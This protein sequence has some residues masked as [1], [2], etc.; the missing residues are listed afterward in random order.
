MMGMQGIAGKEQ[1]IPKLPASPMLKPM[2]TIAASST[3]SDI[4]KQYKKMILIPALGAALILLPKP[5]LYIGQPFVQY[6]PILPGKNKEYSFLTTFKGLLNKTTEKVLAIALT[7]ELFKQIAP[8]IK[9]PYLFVPRSPES[10]ID[11][12]ERPLD[13]TTSASP[14]GRQDY[15]EDIGIT[16][17]SPIEVKQRVIMFSVNNNAKISLEKI[18]LRERWTQKE[19]KYFKIGVGINNLEKPV[20]SSGEI[21]MLFNSI[22][23]DKAKLVS[24]AI[25]NWKIYHKGTYDDNALSKYARFWIALV[26]TPLKQVKAIVPVTNEEITVKNPSVIPTTTLVGVTVPLPKDKSL[27][28]IVDDGR[29]Y[30][31]SRGDN[32]NIF[33]L[34][35]IN[36]PDGIPTQTIIDLS[37]SIY[38]NEPR[39]QYLTHA[40]IGYLLDGRYKYQVG[41]RIDKGNEITILDFNTAKGTKLQLIDELGASLAGS[42]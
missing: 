15:F 3:I 10:W 30:K 5:S 25:Q 22:K 18:G 31:L 24:N 42:P 12:V 6:K 39:D 16:S 26:N 1:Q 29:I 40:A 9:N 35:R 41:I 23:F 7:W 13:K 34:T 38:K 27:K 21:D 33:T 28:I 4:I 11:L 32:E 20:I 14:S 19:I 17:G 36:N 37:S 8:R 2:E